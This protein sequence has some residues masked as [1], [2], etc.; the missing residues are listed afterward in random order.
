M[1]SASR[2]FSDLEVDV[3]ADAPLGPLTWFGIGG[4]ADA[5]VRPRTVEALSTLIARC[6]RDGID[7]RVL[8]DGA[9]LLVADEG[10][11]GVVVK[12]DQPVFRERK[13]NA[14]G[15]VEAVRAMAGVSL[16]R[17]I[18]EA[19]G[20]GLAG[21]EGLGGIPASIGGAVRM[22]AGGA[23]GAISDALHSIA[24]IDRRGEVGVHPA[25]SLDLSYRHASIPGVIVLWAAFRLVEGD[26]VALRDRLKEVMSYKSS[27]QP[28]AGHSAGCMFKNP[29]ARAG[30]PG[31]R[32]SA[33]KLIDQTGLKG[34]R[35]GGAVVSPHHA[36]FFLV[37]PGAT[38]GDVVSLAELVAS[39]VED[40]F[41][42]RLEREVVVWDRRPVEES[43]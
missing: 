3:Q 21:L 17:L 24:V 27:T 26:P 32:T 14:R 40:R 15:S 8:G 13:L 10:V 34:T 43:P 42:V 5:L 4:R 9:N 36:N 31:P 6:H 2:L 11:S 41:G 30:E 33:G 39:R 38:A 18:T 35:I 23:F 12:L 28:L 20:A 19:V 1:A 37:E 16:P 22:N 25:S 29:P 7:F